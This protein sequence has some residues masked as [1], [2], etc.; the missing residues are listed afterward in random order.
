MSDF[1]ARAKARE[2]AWMTSGREICERDDPR[3]ESQVEFFDQRFWNAHNQEH[4][5]IHGRCI[6]GCS[7]ECLYELPRAQTGDTV[8]ICRH[9]WEPCEEQRMAP[10]HELLDEVWGKDR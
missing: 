6:P 4:A 10:L 1:E 7:R 9:T 3:T 2:E 8:L 5:K